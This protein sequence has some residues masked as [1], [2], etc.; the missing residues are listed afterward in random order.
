MAVIEL[1]PTLTLSLLGTLTSLLVATWALSRRS[2]GWDEAERLKKRLEGDPEKREKGLIDQF[3]DLK[4]D[5]YERQ[6]PP[7]RDAIQAA[8]KQL[9]WVRRGLSAHGSDEHTIVENVRNSITETA[10]N[11][12]TR[13]ARDTRKMIILEQAAR[14]PEVSARGDEHFVKSAHVEENDPFP[15]DRGDRPSSHGNERESYPSVMGRLDTSRHPALGGRRPIPR[16]DPDSGDDRPSRP[17]NPDDTGRH[18]GRK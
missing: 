17:F 2:R 8:V 9:K 3:E 15:S 14:F 5:L 4:E 7:L 10:R 6:L 13:I 1:T 18:R 16:E 11:E 12:A